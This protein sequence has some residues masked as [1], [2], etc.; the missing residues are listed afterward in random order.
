MQK[1][2][3]VLLSVLLPMALFNL[4]GIALLTMVWTLPHRSLIKKCSTRSYG[5]IALTE[6]D[7]SFQITPPCVRL[8]QTM[9]HTQTLQHDLRLCLCPVLLRAKSTISPRV[10]PAAHLASLPPC[11]STSPVCL[12]L[13]KNHPVPF[14]F[15]SYILIRCF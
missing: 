5:G 11:S 4:P 13:N 8:A 2:G 14:Y 6:E 10:T 12:G 9:Q 1:H 3:G 7:P 15:R